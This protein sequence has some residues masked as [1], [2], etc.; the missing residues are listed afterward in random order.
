MIIKIN[1]L[2]LKKEI[3]FDNITQ[4]YFYE[5]KPKRGECG[6]IIT[7]MGLLHKYQI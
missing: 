7:N 1:F 6:D 3:F 2:F 4:K 5:Y